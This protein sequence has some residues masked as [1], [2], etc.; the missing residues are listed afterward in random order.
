MAL[1]MYLSIPGLTDK[2]EAQPP[3]TA[4]IGSTPYLQITDFSFSVTNPGGA[5]NTGAGKAQV[6]AG[7]LAVVLP[8]GFFTPKLLQACADGTE[9]ATASLI[10]QTGSLKSVVTTQKYDFK[11]VTVASLAV[12]GSA[13]GD[14][15]SLTFGYRALQIT[16]TPLA[17]QGQPETPSTG[18][19]DLTTGGVT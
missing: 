12:A 18:G 1:S 13:D 5:A 14:Q 16:Y 17:V 15:Q 4:L 3:E 2:N 8:V 19:F 7:S 9:F 10:V 11:A 6:Q